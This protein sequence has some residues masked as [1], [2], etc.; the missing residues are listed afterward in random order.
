MKTLFADASKCTGCLSCEVAC[1][2]RN[3]GVSGRYEARIHVTLDIFGGDNVIN[4]CRQC[5][6]AKCA[7]ACP[8]EAITFDAEGGYWYVN[9]DACTQ[10]GACVESCPFGTLRQSPST[11]KI[12]KCHTCQGSPTC[13]QACGS[14]ALTWEDPAERR[15]AAAASRG[16]SG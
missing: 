1:A 11:G 9:E 3:E 12:L 14:G 6:K 4:Q 8:V 10:C 13:V 5:R 16:A 15:Q 7:E 2:Q